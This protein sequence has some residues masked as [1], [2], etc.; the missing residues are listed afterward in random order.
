MAR[1]RDLRVSFE[2]LLQ[3]IASPVWRQ[4]V[5]GQVPADAEVVAV[6]MDSQYADTVRVRLRSPA[7]G[8]LLGGSLVPAIEPAQVRTADLVPVDTDVATLWLDHQDLL[9]QVHDMKE[10]SL[11]YQYGIAE[12]RKQANAETPMARLK[13]WQA[14]QFRAG[15]R[16]CVFT[17][18]ANVGGFAVT[19]WL[20]APSASENCVTGKSSRSLAHAVERALAVWNKQ[21]PNWLAVALARHSPT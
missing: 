4:T 13:A 16:D 2:I 11:A 15:L 7:F 12:G 19:L 18:M 6:H 21:P 20:D 3:L 1:V 17:Y 5:P 8:D 14:E 10:D 9:K